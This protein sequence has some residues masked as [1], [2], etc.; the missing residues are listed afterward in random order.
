[1]T[2]FYRVKFMSVFFG[3]CSGL[4]DSFGVNRWLLRLLFL[5][6]TMFGGFGIVIYLLVVIALSKKNS[7]K[8]HQ[9]RVFGLCLSL[10]QRYGWDISVLRMIAL[11]GLIVSGILPG[12][13]VY[14]LGS[15][16]FSKSTPVTN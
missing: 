2:K 8:I 15:I 9:K 5:A 13:I 1:M 6:L 10:S 4:E 16:S 14:V 7:P 3:L 12:L 11:F